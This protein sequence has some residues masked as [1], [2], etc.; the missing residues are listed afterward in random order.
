M[1]AP[2]AR[3][4]IE[5]EIDIQ[6]PAE[7]VFDALADPAQ[8][9]Q[10]WERPGRFQ[11][12]HMESDLRPGGAWLM[13]GTGADDKPFTLRGEYRTVERPAVL[14]FSWLPDW[15]E[16]ETLVRFELQEQDGTT[17]VRLTHSGFATDASRERYQGWPW[18]L[19]MLQGFAEKACRR[20]HG[21]LTFVRSTAGAACRSSRRTLHPGPARRE[22]AARSAM[23][24]AELTLRRPHAKMRRPVAARR[25]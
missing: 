19:A 16:Q 12:T 15:E 1:N 5:A 25:L 2:N 10:W 21:I 20:Q 18:L 13:R 3:N 7:R 11:A 17:T 23:P 9:V 24:P 4:A 14:E 6:A 22:P 8:R